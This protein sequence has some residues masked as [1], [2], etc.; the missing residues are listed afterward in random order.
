MMD[1]AISRIL[2]APTLSPSPTGGHASCQSSTPPQIPTAESEF[3][4]GVAG[5]SLNAMQR[6]LIESIVFATVVDPVGPEFMA[7]PQRP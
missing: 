4:L 6:D 7:P 1:F 3:A 2:I 5:W